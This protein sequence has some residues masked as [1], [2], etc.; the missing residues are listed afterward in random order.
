MRS[1]ADPGAVEGDLRPVTILFADIRGFTRLAE[2]LPPEK[3]VGA[4]NGCF[5]VLD[6]GIAHYG[7]E[8]DKFLGDAIMATFG[9]SL[10]HDDDPRRAVLAALEMQSALS[11]LNARLRKQIGCELDMRIGINT[12]VVLAGPIGS[13][14]KRSFTVM[15]GAVEVAGPLGGAAPGGR[16]LLCG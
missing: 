5:E 3:L 2:L 9:E 4:I 15:G 8:I 1:V 14:R 11:L 7:G 16:P 10:A 12:G 13:R 6:E